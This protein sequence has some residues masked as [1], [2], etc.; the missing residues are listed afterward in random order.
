MLL[1]WHAAG[2]TGL[3]VRGSGKGQSSDMT[4]AMGCGVWGVP[5]A[6]SVRVCGV[7]A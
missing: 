4:D 3:A 7:C 5:A 1:A 6:H 2:S